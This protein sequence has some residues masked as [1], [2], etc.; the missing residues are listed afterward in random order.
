MPA[1]LVAGLTGIVGGIICPV[2]DR[3]PPR[4]GAI[5]FQSSVA[6]TLYSM[7]VDI[8]ASVGGVAPSIGVF[9]ASFAGILLAR[10]RPPAQGRPVGHTVAR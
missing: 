4:V 8:E 6:V 7:L 9:A 1:V 2:A 5:P 3:T 10:G